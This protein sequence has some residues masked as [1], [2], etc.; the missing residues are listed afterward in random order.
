M[1]VIS[2]NSLED[3]PVKRFFQERSRQASAPKGMPVVPEG[4]APVLRIVGRAIRAGD[5][6]V[7]ANPRAR[8]AVLRIAERR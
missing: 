1:A 2:F 4:P 6:E 5:A 3:R 7:R 8:S